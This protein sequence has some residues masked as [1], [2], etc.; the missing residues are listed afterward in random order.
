VTQADIDDLEAAAADGWRAPEEAALGAWRLRAAGGFTGRA[1]SALAVGDPGVSIA[2]AIDEVVGWYR[3]RGLR[4]MV[5]IA[6][7]PGRPHGSDVDRFLGQHGWSV[8]HG[9]VVMT[10][11]PAIAA[12]RAAD[13]PAATAAPVDVDEEPDDGWLEMYRPRGRTPPPIARRLLMSASWQ[14][15]G[16]VREGGRT[17]A[18]GRVAVAAGWAGL[19]AV[20]VDPAHR[21]RGLGG[22]IT[23][24][25]AGAAAA[26]GA[27]GIY[28]QVE[29]DNAAARSLYRRRGF[30][31]HHEYHYRAAPIEPV[32]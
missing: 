26:H 14:A 25:L 24:E 3:A 2:T 22:A 4:P 16:S 31:D 5:A 21:R 13:G 20:A 1:N 6:F 10:A 8:D 27:T 30:T 19:T 7:P 17:I 28:L 11:A 15:F 12:V 9:A 32:S 18:I 23:A 29:H